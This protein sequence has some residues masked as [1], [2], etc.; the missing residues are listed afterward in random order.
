MNATLASSAVC[1]LAG[2]CGDDGAEPEDMT[3]GSVR[4][5]LPYASEVVSFELG[6]SGGYGMNKLPGVVLGP[7]KGGGTSAGSLDVLSL[8]ISGEIV[9]GFGEREISDGPGPDLI[10]FENAFWA[11]GDPDAAFTEP[12]EVAVSADGETWHTFACDPDAAIEEAGC[13]GLHPVL[14]YDAAKMLELDP[15]ETGGDAFDLAAIDLPAARYV[16]IRD[17]D[18]AG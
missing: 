10:V 4:A 8:G 12:G 18:G 16:R 15:D 5:E 14:K 17:M 13:A 2:A 9:L 7:P 11:N 1:L 3:D 6:T